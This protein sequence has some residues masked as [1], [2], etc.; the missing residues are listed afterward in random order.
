M[1]EKYLI[2]AAIFLVILFMAIAQMFIR[3][4]TKLDRET[5]QLYTEIKY[6]P[7]FIEKHFY[8]IFFFQRNR[9]WNEKRLGF[10]KN[11]HG[12]L[13]RDTESPTAHGK[14][15]TE[16]LRKNAQHWKQTENMVVAATDA[17]ARRTGNA[18]MKTQRP[19]QQRQ[20]D[21]N[22]CA[23]SRLLI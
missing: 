4:L 18:I 6:L 17:A 16:T 5:R 12:Q 3:D 20:S 8:N 13:A 15:P 7:D 2:C 22:D 14:N 1:E 10:N 23:F 11:L 19:L 9:D 21:T